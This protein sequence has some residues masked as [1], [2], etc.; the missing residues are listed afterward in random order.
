[1]AKELSQ[2]IQEIQPKYEEAK[3]LYEGL[4]KL[5]LIDGRYFKNAHQMVERP[6]DAFY[7]LEKYFE[8]PRLPISPKDSDSVVDGLTKILEM[9][10]QGLNIIKFQ[11][12]LQLERTVKAYK[13]R[14]YR[15][16][17]SFYGLMIDRA[18]ENLPQS[19]EYAKEHGIKLSKTF[20]T[21]KH[22]GEVEEDLDLVG[23]I[24]V[25]TITPQGDYEQF[26]AVI[27]EY[28]SVLT[29][30]TDLSKKVDGALDST[31]IDAILLQDVLNDGFGKG[32]SISKMVLDLHTIRNGIGI[33]ESHFGK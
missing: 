29:Q 23:E 18:I 31:S 5:P 15:L 28:Q 8:E 16:G 7:T 1:M 2:R 14:L 17:E 30:L 21:E 27:S 32:V 26:E 24:F 25:A 22:S 6:Q 9:T 3:R 20:G 4:Q 11:F 10:L 33:L 19:R 13:Q 12:Q